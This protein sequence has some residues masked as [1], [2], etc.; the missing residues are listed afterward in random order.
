M[1]ALF[2]IDGTEVGLQQPG[3]VLRFG[4]RSGL[5]GVRVTD[6]G[7]PVSWRVAVLLF[8]GFKKVVGTV[9]LV[10]VQRFDERVGEDLD[11]PGCFPHLAGQDDGRVEPDNVFATLNEG[12]P[13]LLFDV[14]FE[15]GSQRAVVPC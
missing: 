14:L 12:L 9:T 13:P 8:V 3:E 11:V 2:V 1:H 4:P 10:G 15:S 6:V 7:K 5:T